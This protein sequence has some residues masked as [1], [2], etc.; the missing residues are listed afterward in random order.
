MRP[1]RIHDRD[2]D[3]DPDNTGYSHERRNTA[4][5]TDEWNG[6]EAGTKQP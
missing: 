6:T 5:D 2:R 1:T 4:L 3:R